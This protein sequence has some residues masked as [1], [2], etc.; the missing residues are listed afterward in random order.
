MP[1]LATDAIRLA[2]YTY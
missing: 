2:T 1:L